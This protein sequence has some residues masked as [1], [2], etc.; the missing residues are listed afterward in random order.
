MCDVLGSIPEGTLAHNITVIEVGKDIRF[1]IDEKERG[2]EKLRE[3]AKKIKASIRL[4]TDHVYMIT[5][6]R[7]LLRTTP[8]YLCTCTCSTATPST[9]MFRPV[10]SFRLLE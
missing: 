2:R 10:S 9:L 5:R 1:E 6:V 3:S 8:R 4:S 7:E